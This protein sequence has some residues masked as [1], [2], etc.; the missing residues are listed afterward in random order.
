MDV[1][2]YMSIDDA[3]GCITIEALKEG[4]GVDNPR[5]W[6]DVLFTAM[7]DTDPAKSGLDN[8]GRTCADYSL[9]PASGVSEYLYYGPG[10]CAWRGPDTPLPTLSGASRTS[11]KCIYNSIDCQGCSLQRLPRDDWQ[12]LTLPLLETGARM[13]A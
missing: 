3:G 2:E 8:N 7:P 11:S 4:T 6:E 12:S 10:S 5:V 13:I 1:S 9:C